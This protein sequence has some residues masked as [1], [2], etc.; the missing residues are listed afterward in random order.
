MHSQYKLFISNGLVQHPFF[1][2]PSK[3]HLV[4]HIMPSPFPQSLHQ[5][6]FG[7]EAR[8][9]WL[10]ARLAPSVGVQSLTPAILVGFG[11]QEV[12]QAPLFFPQVPLCNVGIVLGEIWLEWWC[13][14]GSC[15]A[16][17]KEQGCQQLEVWKPLAPE[18]ILL[19]WSQEAIQWKAAPGAG[20]CALVPSSLSQ[21]WIGVDWDHIQ[22]NG[23]VTQQRFLPH[24]LQTGFFL[25]PAAL[26]QHSTVPPPSLVKWWG[27]WLERWS[28]GWLVGQHGTQIAG[29][30]WL[31][32]GGSG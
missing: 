23:P 18:C 25:C 15:G 3:L 14:R 5:G 17:G 8:T 6:C 30:L 11:W 32:W 9:G 12:M 27:S 7:D 13:N 21:P 4:Q 1:Y 26:A 29:P 24:P 28:Q 20:C 10:P 31:K 22:E 19:L 16:T 2:N